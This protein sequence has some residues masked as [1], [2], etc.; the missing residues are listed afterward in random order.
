MYKINACSM[1]WCFKKNPMSRPTWV[2]KSEICCSH[3]MRFYC[4]QMVVFADD[5][6]VNKF[7]EWYARVSAPISK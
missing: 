6:V 3:R 7:Q 4:C 2:E 5:L 1:V